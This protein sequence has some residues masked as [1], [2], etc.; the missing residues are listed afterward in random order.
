M[1]I[2]WFTVGAQALNFVILVWLMR[3][4]LYKPI[5]RAIDAREKRIAAELASADAAKAEAERERTELKRKNEEFDQHRT[6]LLE[7]AT[8]EANAARKNLLDEARRAA[9]ALSVR[10]QQSLMSDARELNQSISRRAQQEVFAIAR[11]ALTDLASTNLEERLC[12]VF[13]RRLREMGGPAKARLREA[14]ETASEPALVRSAFELSAKQRAA[15]QNAINETFS[16]DIRLRFDTAPSLV[17]GIELTSNGQKVAWSIA[18]YLTSLEKAVGELLVG[19]AAS[20]K[21]VPGPDSSGSKPAV[22][23]AVRAP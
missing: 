22:E 12:E 10:R 16:A 17:G 6:A 13:T 1:L 8:N 2:D 15:V 11:K 4:F 7:Q 14:I 18:G 3:R 23:G 19:Q 20:E 21:S 5:L 9:D